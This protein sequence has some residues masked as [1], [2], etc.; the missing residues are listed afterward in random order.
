MAPSGDVNYSDGNVRVFTRGIKDTVKAL[1]AA[2]TDVQDIKEA[3]KRVGRIVERDVHAPVGAT[4]K[5]QA[6]VRLSA[7]KNASKIRAGGVRV[8]YAAR[9]EYG[10]YLHLKNGGTSRQPGRFFFREA[11]RRKRGAVIDQLKLELSKLMA[12]HDLGDPPIRV[13]S[14]SKTD[15]S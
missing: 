8:P 11:I 2:G 4:G 7:T 12:K 14:Y 15:Y 9:I 1:E 5:L 6:S 13:N 10:V 3:M